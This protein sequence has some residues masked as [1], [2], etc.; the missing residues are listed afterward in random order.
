M[1]TENA[2]MHLASWLYRFLRW[3]LGGIFI[4]SGATKLIAPQTFAVLIEAYGIVPE[5]LLMPMAIVLPAMELI[6]GTGLLIDLRGSLGVMTALLLLFVVILSY[7]IQMGLDVD[8]GCFSVEDPEAEAYHGLRPALYRDLA[9]LAAVAFL[10]GWRRFRL[11]G[12]L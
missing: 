1:P 11:A 7:G 3:I 8:C 5:T 2:L 4:Y 6:A 9:L 12:S 10:Y